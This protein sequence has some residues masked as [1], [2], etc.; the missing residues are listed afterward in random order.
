MYH[1]EPG[2][3]LF[4]KLIFIIMPAS[5]LGLSYYLFS[6][7]DNE[8]G[9]TLLAEAFI[10]GLILFS[11]SPRR[12]EVYE[13]RL[14]IVLGGFFSV[15][16]GF[17]KIKA[18]HTGQRMSFSV[19]YATRVTGKYVLI[20]RKRGLSITITPKDHEAFVENANRALDE[21]LKTQPQTMIG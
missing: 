11:V 1:D 12:Y 3:G 16:I 9:L 5:L 18:I 2:Y 15:N 4:L 21:W 14:H 13:D 20:D 17:E 8:D 7:G 6:R 10:F 19:N